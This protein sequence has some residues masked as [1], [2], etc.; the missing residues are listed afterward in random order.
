[1][2]DQTKRNELAE[3]SLIAGRKA[4]VS[5]AYSSALKYL[6]TGIELLADDSWGSKYDITLALY[7]TAAEAAYLS[8]D[9]EYTEKCAQVVLVKAKTPLDRVKAYEVEIQSY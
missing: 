7:N 4:L 2:T 5:T 3:M 1:I 8:G 6:T 9:F